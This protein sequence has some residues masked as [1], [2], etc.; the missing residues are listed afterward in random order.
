MTELTNEPG[1]NPAVGPAGVP[2]DARV[3]WPVLP[4]QEKVRDA[5]VAA[6]LERLGTLPTLPVADHGKVYAGWHA[7]L[8]E[9]LNDAGDHAS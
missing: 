1:L 4:A 3:D 5:D 8:M 6:L 7:D 2:E 9:A